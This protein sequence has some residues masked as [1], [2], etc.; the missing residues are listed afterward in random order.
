MSSGDASVTILLDRL[1]AGDSGAFGPLIEAVY[2]DVHSLSAARLRAMCGRETEWTIQPTIIAHDV[3]LAFEEQRSIPQNR[4]HFFAIAARI[5][6]R[7]LAAY[8]DAREA[9]KRGGGHHRVPLDADLIPDGDHPQSVDHQAAVER[10][11]EALRLLHEKSPRQA[12]VASLRLY[13]KLTVPRIAAILKLSEA[14]VHRDW[15][16]AKVQLQRWCRETTA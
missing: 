7:T 3:L 10:G 13:G 6:M 5:I 1:S 2:K 8:R 16:E 11:L 12:E 14:T 9:L 4:E 15:A